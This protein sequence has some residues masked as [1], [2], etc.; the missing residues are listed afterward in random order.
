MR[1]SWPSREMQDRWEF[2]FKAVQAFAI[3]VGA[4]WVL[5]TY[6]ITAAHQR[7]AVERELRTPYD[8]KQLA[9]Y[10]DSARVLAH[11]AAAPSL[12]RE[13]TEARFWELY[14]GELAF[15]ESKHIEELM[16]AF[17]EKLFAPEDKNL[18]EQDKNLNEQLAKKRKA[19]HTAKSKDPLKPDTLE[20]AAI[21]MSRDAS[22]EIRG[23]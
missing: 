1:W 18:N 9:L 4:F 5:V 22:E 2:V 20:A 21:N 10:L 3:V 6:T 8:E 16:V 13:K 12:E 7:S 19:C 23:H 11:L 15:V 17:C 14:W